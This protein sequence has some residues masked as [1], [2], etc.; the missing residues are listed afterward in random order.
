MMVALEKD[1]M[2]MFQEVEE[3]NREVLYID[4]YNAHEAQKNYI[5]IKEIE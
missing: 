5:K 3:Y 1:V 4:H 2:R